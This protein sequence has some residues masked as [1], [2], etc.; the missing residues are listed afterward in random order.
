MVNSTLQSQ[1]SVW[2][3]EK[4]TENALFSYIHIFRQ[5]MENMIRNVVW[6]G[7]GWC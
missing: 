1:T 4:A 7:G 3:G 5:R 6:L 2:V